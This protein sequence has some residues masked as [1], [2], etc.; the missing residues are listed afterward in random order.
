MIIPIDIL[1][2]D[3]PRVVA[4]FVA[5]EDYEN[6]QLPGETQA[7]FAKRMFAETLNDYVMAAERRVIRQD[8]Q[9]EADAITPITVAV[10]A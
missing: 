4:A 8:A 10:G 6:T 3:V 7:E 5:A 9:D 2:A 1:D